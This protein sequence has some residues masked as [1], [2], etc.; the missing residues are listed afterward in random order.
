[1]VRDPRIAIDDMLVAIDRIVE[2]TEDLRFEQF[3]E[4]WRLQYVVERAL[5][6]VSEASRAIPSSF[7]ERRIDVR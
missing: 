7:K 6:I 2:E 4:N 1:M 5:L 3:A